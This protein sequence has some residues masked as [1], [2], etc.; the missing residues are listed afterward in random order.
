MIVTDFFHTQNSHPLRCFSVL[1][2]RLPKIPSTQIESKEQSG[3]DSQYHRAQRKAVASILINPGRT[4]DSPSRIPD[5]ITVH[6]RQ[7]DNDTGIRPNADEE[8]GRERQPSRAVARQEEKIPQ[9]SNPKDRDEEDSPFLEVI[10]ERPEEKESRSG[11]DKDRN[12]QD[13]SDVQAAVDDN[14]EYHE[15]SGDTS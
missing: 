7:G 2:P 9:G 6:P 1:V 13:L 14:L 11:A 3:D 10:G 15:V 4:T 12:R 5:E 8:S